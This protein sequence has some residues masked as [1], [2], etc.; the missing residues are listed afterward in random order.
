MLPVGLEKFRAYV[1]HVKFY[2]ETVN[3]APTWCLSQP[4]QLGRI[5]C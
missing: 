3:K 5:G 1:K 4:C 2:L